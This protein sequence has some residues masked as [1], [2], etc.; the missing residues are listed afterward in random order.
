MSTTYKS[1]EE[2]KGAMILGELEDNEW[3]LLIDNDEVVLEYTGELPPGMD[4]DSE[5]GRAWWVAHNAEHVFKA[6]P[7]DILHD[8][9]L[10]CG[11]QAEGV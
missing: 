6:D 5:E 10:M 8:A 7:D 3:T 11:F 9:L 2:L 4:I 1:L